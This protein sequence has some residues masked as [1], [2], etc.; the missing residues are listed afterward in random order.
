MLPFKRVSVHVQDPLGGPV[1][2]VGL[3]T[4]DSYN[5]LQIGGESFDT[6]SGYPYYWPSVY[7]D[8]N[9]DATL[10]LFPSGSGGKYIITAAPPPET[11]YAITNQDAEVVADT[12]LTIVLTQAV[13]LSGR[14][15]DAQGNAVPNVSVG[16]Q[17]V[18]GGSPILRTTDPAGQY[19]F[20]VA[21][22]DYYVYSPSETWATSP[23][24][25]SLPT[26]TSRQSSDHLD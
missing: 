18:A 9:G 8:A 16:L 4:N 15:L 11:L 13:T 12:S 19:S 2:N 17:S 1:P 21:T 6:T 23:L 10:W 25:T 14:L 22:G 5:S 7:T 3:S 24:P 26:P 20:Q